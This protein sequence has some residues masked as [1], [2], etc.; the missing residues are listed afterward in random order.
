VASSTWHTVM[1]GEGTLVSNS[2]LG[3][4][5]PPG[6]RLARRSSARSS[7]S[8]KS[9]ASRRCV[10]H[11][12]KFREKMVRAAA[13]CKAGPGN[14]HRQRPAYVLSALLREGRWFAEFDCGAAWSSWPSW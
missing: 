6:L 10:G 7:I 5:R 8:L 9:A 2:R 13:V 12:T 1:Q 4:G 11:P 3:L 14:Y